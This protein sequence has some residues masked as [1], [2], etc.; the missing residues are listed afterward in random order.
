MNRTFSHIF[1]VCSVLILAFLLSNQ[2]HAAW[3][4][5][6]YSAG[7]TLNPEC[8]PTQTN[9]DVSPTTAVGNGGTGLTSF[10]LGDLLYATTSSALARLGIGTE[11]QVLKV[12]SGTPVWGEDS[13]SGATFAQITNGS[14]VYLDYRPNNVACSADQVLKYNATSS[15]W[16]CSNDNGGTS[17]TADGNGL[18]LSSATFGLELDGT[19]LSSSASGLRISSGYTGQTSITTLGTITSGTWNGGV[20][21]IAYG[22]TG[23]T[24]VP[25]NGQLLIGNGSGYS[26]ATLGGS[27]GISISSGAGSATVALNVT[28]LSTISSADTDDYL[29]V[30]DT[31]AG[32]NKKIS[33]NDLFGDVLG[34]LNYQG[35]WNAST[36]S[37]SL[38]GGTG[39]KGHYYVVS[40]A[41]STSID[42]ISSWS[43]GDWIV[44]NGTAWQKVAATNAVASVFGRT[45]SITAQSGDYTATQVTSSATGTISATTVQDA[46]T[47]LMNEKEASV[48]A[49]TSAQYYRGDKTWQTLTTAAVTEHASA[50]YYTD[51]RARAALSETVTGLSYA[52]SSGV[53]SLDASYNIPLTA[54]TTNFNTAYSWGNHASAGYAVLA[55]ASG[56]Q[57]LIGGTAANNTL[58]LQA[59]SASAGNTSTNTGIQFKVGNSG[60]TTA[61]TLLNSG[62]I[63]IGTTTPGATLSIGGSLRLT[64]ALYDNANAS[65]TQGMVLL[66]TGTSTQWVATSSLGITGSGGSGSGTVS[67]GTI[68]QVAFYG[69]SGTTVS[70][71]STLVITGNRVGVGSSTPF[72][73]FS[74]TGTAGAHPFVIA[75]S[76]GLQ[77]LTLLQNGNFG[78]GTTTPQ[79]KLDVNGDFALKRGNDYSTTGISNDIVFSTSS[80][81][82]LTGSSAQTVTGIANGVDGKILVLMNAGSSTATI[83]HQSSSSTAANRII[84]G[85]GSDLSVLADA[86]V[87]L[88]YDARDSR[89][90][91]ISSS[92]GSAGS[93]GSAAGVVVI[94]RRASAY[95]IQ[96]ST[97]S[98][99]FDTES[100]DRD[101]AHNTSTGV[102]TVPTS[103]YYEF[104]ATVQIL[105]PSIS[106]PTTCLMVRKGGTV[107][108]QSC[109]GDSNDTG[110]GATNPNIYISTVLSLVAG[111]TVD[112][113]MAKSGSMGTMAFNVANGSNIMYIK[114][115]GTVPMNQISAAVGTSTID[116]TS[117]GQVWNWS[118]LSTSTALTIT[119]NGLTSGTG[120]LITSTSSSLTGDLT[121]FEIN[122]SSTGVTG[123]AFKAGIVSASSTG[124][125]VNFTNAGDGLSFR[126]NDDGTYADN[127]AFVIDASGNVGINNVTPSTLLHIGSS[128][129]SSGN[130]ITIQD[131]NGTCTLDPGS[132]ASWS[133]SSDRTLK[134]NIADLQLGLEVISRLRPTT[135]QMNVDGSERVGFIAQEVQEILPGLVTR[136]PDGKLGVSEG[137]LMPYLV[138]AVQE[139]STLS[140][141]F[142][143]TL[144]EWLANASNGITSIFA[145]KA[146]V[147]E[148]CIGT[149]CITESQLRTLINA[150]SIATTTISTTHSN[151]LQTTSTSTNTLMSTSTIGTSTVA[152]TTQSTNTA[153]STTPTTTESVSM[154]TSSSTQSQTQSSNQD[155]TVESTTTTNP[156]I[157][158]EISTID[159]S[160]PPTE[161]SPPSDTTPTH[162]SASVETPTVPS[163]PSES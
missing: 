51:A 46:L 13:T 24:T 79:T 38:S 75:S 154:T 1:F 15:R 29:I 106:N 155:S 141:Q 119:P 140:T 10:T 45:G 129:I 41:G 131:A 124:T 157:S 126:V 57:T 2:V 150:T 143:T 95:T 145:Q 105:S 132:G 144:I 42:G 33:R 18:E 161:S 11:G 4:G 22:G 149:T 59:N 91:V 52:T 73:T 43:V 98:I 128:T 35:S 153:S 113:A 14:G 121:R 19:S 23:T 107:Q 160:V 70:G 31:S 77:L 162:P 97:T 40:T 83:A 65:G 12:A 93:G 147:Q 109:I 25:S 120:L 74:L 127:T 66:S 16:E 138:K 56:G 108:N 125:V 49:G 101:S 156:T 88:Q 20:L 114:Q 82:R 152:S 78:I 116:N 134:Y 30:Y 92:V 21:G 118:T 89:W 112:F 6:Y 87:L 151:Q 50:L 100:L 110:G 32:A 48:T 111:D 103:G 133:C 63:G 85:T 158:T 136:L 130:M 62:N 96:T 5:S 27:G 17:F 36:N 76:T 67:S 80:L 117:Y 123:T 115:I 90:R 53:L 26:L 61:M 54:S 68:G 47:E 148:L 104:Y 139:I 39:T 86:S 64:G 163:T 37:P 159:Q 69:A 55:G 137:G 142:K 60:A 34:S 9:C 102:F 94:A 84:T 71:T 3:S 122:G 8:S 72:A 146:T 44:Y 58:V 135:F 28:G 7:E 81:I 99:A